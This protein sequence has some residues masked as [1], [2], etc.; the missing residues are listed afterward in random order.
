MHRLRLDRALYRVRRSLDGAPEQ[1][2]AALPPLRRRVVACPSVARSCGFA[3][4]PVG[5]GTERVAET[6]QEIFK[7]E[8]LLRLDRDTATNGAELEAIVERVLSGAVRILV[9][10]QMVTKGHHFPDMSLVVVL[11]ADQGLF[12]TDYR[13]AERLAQTIIQVAGRAGREH[14][15]GE[16]LIQTEYPEHPLLQSLLSGGYAGFAATALTEREAAQWPPFTRLA[17]LRASATSADTALDFLNA[18]RE[19]APRAHQVQVLGPV[20]ASMARRAGRYYAQLLIECR[21]RTALHRFLDQWLPRSRIWRA[22]TACDSRWM[23]IRWRF[24]D[25]YR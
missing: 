3:V 20:A 22:R 2:R 7:D 17:L 15:R 21:E 4:K 8:P 14:K 24:S 9:G 6:L 10:T 12:S 5:Q 1:R 16:V 25:R 11:N 23:W 13:A 18:A 19:G